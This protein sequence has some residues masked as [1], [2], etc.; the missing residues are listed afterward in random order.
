M[1]S[2][3]PFQG[4]GRGYEFGSGSGVRYAAVFV[5]VTWRISVRVARVGFG[6]I[7]GD[8]GP[9]ATIRKNPSFSLGDFRYCDAGCT[10]S[11]FAGLWID[12]LRFGVICGESL[13][14]D[15]DAGHVVT[16]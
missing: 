15:E 14:S 4:V 6:A 2:L 11:F 5:L 16:E 9:D 7:G 3:V 10:E 8:F 1:V 13:D 12:L